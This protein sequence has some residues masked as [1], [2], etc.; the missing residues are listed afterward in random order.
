MKAQQKQEG[1]GGE[2]EGGGGMLEIYPLCLRCLSDSADALVICN[3][4]M[5]ARGG[6][7][8]GPRGGQHDPIFEQQKQV[9]IQQTQKK[10]FK[11]VV[12]VIVLGP[13]LCTNQLGNR[14]DVITG[15]NMTS[16]SWYRYNVTSW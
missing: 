9:H 15:L 14:C 3:K 16:Y 5:C 10:L 1:G 13:D 12:L 7:R 2:E 6:H 4:Y 8:K 11:S